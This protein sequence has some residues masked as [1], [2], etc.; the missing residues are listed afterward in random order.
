MQTSSLR[1][2][3]K[4]P[5]SPLKQRKLPRRRLGYQWKKKNTLFFLG[6]D[7]DNGEQAGSVRRVTTIDD[8]Y[9][10]GGYSK[11][12]PAIITLAK[13]KKK[14]HTH[15]SIAE[16]INSITYFRFRYKR[17][18]NRSIYFGYF[19]PIPPHLF[20]FYRIWMDGSYTTRWSHSCCWPAAWLFLSR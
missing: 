8:K 4:T 19:Q 7:Y 6:F 10:T 2:D 15:V 11:Y 20:N 13:E 9:D 12:K 3:Y 17:V 5:Q 18:I 14:L 16:S 1:K